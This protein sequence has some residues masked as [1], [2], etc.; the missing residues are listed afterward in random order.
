[1][2]II[3]FNMMPLIFQGVKQFIFNFSSGMPTPDQR[4]DIASVDTDK[5]KHR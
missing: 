1:M 4:P 3:V 5:H 2:A